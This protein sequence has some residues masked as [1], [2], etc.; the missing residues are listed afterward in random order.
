MDKKI[1]IGILPM[2]LVAGCVGGGTVIIPEANCTEGEVLGYDCPN[3]GTLGWCDCVNGEWDCITDDPLSLCYQ[4]DP[5]DNITSLSEICN[6]N[7]FEAYVIGNSMT[8]ENILDELKNY[9]ISLETDLDGCPVIIETYYSMFD[10]YE[11]NGITTYLAECDSKC[12]ETSGHRLFSIMWKV[13]NGERIIMSYPS[14][15]LIAY[16]NNCDN[17]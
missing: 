14:T 12:D 15:G 10:S 17:L 11:S 8:D 9:C 2:I 13:E 6:V 3:G 4:S 1:L 16:N 7:D 5:S